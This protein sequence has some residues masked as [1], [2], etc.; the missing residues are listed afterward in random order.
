MGKHLHHFSC[1]Q[2]THRTGYLPATKN[3]TAKIGAVVHRG[4]WLIKSR[5]PDPRFGSSSLKAA[6]AVVERDC[7]TVS[8]TTKMD[9]S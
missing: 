7:S 5:V 9:S 8:R 1:V 6:A 4:S 3:F 2:L